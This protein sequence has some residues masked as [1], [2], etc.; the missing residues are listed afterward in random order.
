MVAIFIEVVL[1]ITKAGI[2]S[3][4]LLHVLFLVVVSR[5]VGF[6]SCDSSVRHIGKD[7]TMRFTRVNLGD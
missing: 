2:L 3:F 5:R 7:L 1:E 4:D 6:V